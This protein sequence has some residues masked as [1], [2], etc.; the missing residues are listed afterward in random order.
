MNGTTASLLDIHWLLEETTQRRASERKLD[1]EGSLLVKRYLEM[2]VPYRLQ[3]LKEFAES[4]EEVD[5]AMGELPQ[6][7]EKLVSER[8][9]LFTWVQAGPDEGEGDKEP[10]SRALDEL[11]SFTEELDSVGKELDRQAYDF[12]LEFIRNS[13]L[14]KEMA[15]ALLEGEEASHL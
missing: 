4:L 5:L 3:Q 11:A 2:D 9:R 6:T 14:P 1:M 13:K 8:E 10:G 15:A 7:L 12:L